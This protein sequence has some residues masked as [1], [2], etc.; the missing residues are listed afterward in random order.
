MRSPYPHPPFHADHV[1]SLLRPPEL[2]AAR[3]RAQK[4][5]IGPAELREIEDACIRD[6]VAMQETAGLRAITDGEYRRAVYH[7]DFLTQLEGIEARRTT[8]TGGEAMKFKG[9]DAK[10]IAQQPPSMMVVTGKIRHAKPILVDHFKF[11]KS[12]TRGT[13]KMCVPTPGHLHLRAGRRS[14]L[15]E[16]YP[17]LDE[18]WRDIGAAI[19]TE[20]HELYAAGCR[21]VQ[22][23]ETCFAMLSDPGVRAEI[24]ARGENPDAL[25]ATYARMI[26]MIVADRP[27]DLTVVMHT[28][29]GNFRSS[30]MAAGGYDAVSDAVFSSIG[31]DGL[32]LE[33]DDERSGGFAPLANVPRDRKVVLGLV[34]S[35]RGALEASDELKRRIEEAARY[36]PLENLGLS[37]QCGF[38]STMH[39]NALT[40]DD[41]RRKLELVVSVAREVWGDA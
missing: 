15:E 10:P 1:G 33:Y 14:I 40:H 18:F 34:S 2:L 36:V 35:K 16:V 3:E 24:V 19:R 8:W 37:P 17:D 38:A 4:G 6:A 25:P 28:C 31:V 21:Y 20:L 7:V 27:A 9:R 13:P 12:V 11:L 22:L 39:G 30:W 26:N 41:Q 23:D 29:R 5:E 32:F